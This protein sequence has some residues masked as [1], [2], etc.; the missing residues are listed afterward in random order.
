MSLELKHHFGGTRVELHHRFA[1][2]KSLLKLVFDPE[3]QFGECFS[4]GTLRVKGDLVRLLLLLRECITED[5]M[6]G[7]LEYL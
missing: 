2:R 1:D 4:E 7:H 6:R 5:E 3:F